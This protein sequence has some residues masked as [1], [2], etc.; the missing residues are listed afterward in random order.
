LFIALVKYDTVCINQADIHERNAQVRRMKA[1]YEEVEQVVVWL[2][3]KP[4]AET[5]ISDDA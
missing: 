5:C 4:M 3:L 1:T 2:E